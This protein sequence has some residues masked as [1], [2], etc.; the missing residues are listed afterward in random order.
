MVVYEEQE[1]GTIKAYS[2]SGKM[3]RGGFPEGLYEEAY[4]PK[5][6]HRTYE[7][8]DIPVPTHEE[9]VSTESNMI[10]E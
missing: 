1:D 5:E 8:T 9:P 7:E 3:I 2:D 4:D 6:L 10:E